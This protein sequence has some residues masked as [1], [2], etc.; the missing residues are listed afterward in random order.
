MLGSGASGGST[1]PRSGPCS[2]HTPPNGFATRAKACL[3]SGLGHKVTHGLPGV[4]MGAA[5]ADASLLVAYVAATLLGGILLA[6]P[7]S[8]AGTPRTH[9][10]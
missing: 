3:L 4:A 6:L 1:A 7:E 8:D 9:D 2:P 10:F 5:P